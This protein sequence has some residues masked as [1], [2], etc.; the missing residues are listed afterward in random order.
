MLS[1]KPKQAFFGKMFLGK[2]RT[3][4]PA[5]ENPG[6]KEE[7]KTHC[8]AFQWGYSGRTQGKWNINRK[9]HLIYNTQNKCLL[10]E[11]QSERENAVW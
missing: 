11:K 6:R 9:W 8:S 5:T 10:N 4:H 3:K 1:Q 2:K 7:S